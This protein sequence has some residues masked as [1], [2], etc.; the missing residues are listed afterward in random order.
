MVVAHA[1]MSRS[2]PRASYRLRDVVLDVG[3][4]TLSRDGRIVRLERQPMELLIL[5][6]ERRGQLVT[7]A[8]I[9]DLL[10][11]KDVFVDVETGVHTAIRKIRQA[12][13]DAPESPTFIETVAGKGYRFVAPVEAMA[14]EVGSPTLVPVA[15]A[16]PPVAQELPPPAT[17]MVASE[18]RRAW[19][20]PVGAVASLL[21]ALAALASLVGWPA[22]RR[23]GPNEPITIAVL[24][25]ELLGG[26]PAN[27]YL[28]DGLMEDTIASLGRIDPG[29]ITVIGRTSM[30]AYR[31]TT[32]SIA[33]IGR[34]L[35]A[36]YLV[37]GSLRAEGQRLRITSQLV[38]PAD[39]VQVW[40]QSFDR[41]VGSTFGVQ[42]ELSRSIADE[43]R[44]QLSPA[45]NQA[46]D[47][48]H[49][50]NE[51]AF[52]YFLRGR[53]AFHHRTPDGMRE[54]VAAFQ[55]ATELDPQ[56]ALAWASL[57]MSHAMRA[58]NSDAD[59]RVAL[60][61]SR[62]AAQL[63]VNLDPELAEAQYTLGYVRWLLEW[64]WSGAETAFRRA[65]AL[66]PS[67]GL[68]HQSLGRLL[69]QS[70]R[71]APAQAELRRARELDPLDPVPAAMASQAAFQARDFRAALD[72][73]HRAIT[74]NPGFWYGYQMQAQ[75][76]AQL[77]ATDA[78]MQSALRAIQLSGRNSK[79]VSLHGYLLARYGHA[80]E[81]RALIA[82]LEA[83]AAKTYV[84][85]YTM[86]LVQAGLGDRD[87]VFDWLERAYAVRDVHLIYLPV[88][89]KWDS[90]RSDP[91]FIALLA[92]CGFTTRRPPST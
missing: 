41:V 46:L 3:A 73:A 12:L 83:Q 43:V 5:L 87:G 34:E 67:F 89:V 45:A 76:E 47:R 10:W 86:A 20:R 68:V 16:P 77:S 11:G 7:R 53:A 28:A 58:I 69:S 24:P 50:R 75:A 62:Q 80:A 55:R 54:A 63:A 44:I 91:R 26:D 21:V 92:R 66:D 71:H 65:I 19:V 90:Y 72:L 78:A 84:P 4:Y 85:P 64:D 6:V 9:V 39:Q 74:L 48:R 29:R 35:G 27:A 37:E 25:F 31:H 22:A 36:D 81:A 23:A 13:R 56:Y 82:S 49:S 59:P 15:S 61:L 40:S 32:K 30:Q 88:D 79:P 14:P 33:E 18:P 42:Q 8:E 52:D 57:G 1:T 17:D 2:D 38:R 60:R 51:D 70:G